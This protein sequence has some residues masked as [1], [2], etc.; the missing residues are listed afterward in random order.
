MKLLSFFKKRRQEEEVFEEREG[1][2]LPATSL[3]EGVSLEEVKASGLELIDYLVRNRGY[4]YQDIAKMI[5]QENGKEFASTVPEDVQRVGRVLISA[6][7]RKRYHYLPIGDVVVPKNVFEQFFYMFDEEREITAGEV[8]TFVYEK[9]MKVFKSAPITDVFIDAERDTYVISYKELGGGKRHYMTI[10]YEQGRKVI[11]HLKARAAMYSEV[12]ITVSDMPQSG[13]IFYPELGLE[14][15]IEFIPTTLGECASLRFLDVKGYFSATLEKLGYPP[16][17][18]AALREIAKKSQGFVLVG[19]PTGSGKSTMIKAVLLEVNPTEKVIRAVEDP[20][21]VIV[22]GITHVQVNSQTTFA[23]A[24]KSFMRANPDCIFVGE[25]RDSETAVRF[26]EAAMTGH[27]AFSTI[28]A[29][30]AVENLQRLAIKI[31]EGGLFTERE[32]YK[33]MASNLLASI[34]TRLVKRKDRSGVVPLV[35]LFIPDE[36]DRRLIEEGDF[37]ALK[38]RLRE[39]GEDLYT[40][41]MRLVEQG[42]IDKEEVLKYLVEIKE[43]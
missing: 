22:Q 31:L 33:I 36:E 37:L 39:K 13:K 30:D 15:R 11:E 23:D 43:A 19:G 18:Q 20:V 12:S 14:I 38:H 41:G 6:S 1:R 26:L 27:L 5:A 4:S 10:A 3:L 25:I 7:T 2:I 32:L 17:V 8:S 28:H 24:I 40:E 34:S 29:N 42:I 35:E 16:K 9:I 21:E